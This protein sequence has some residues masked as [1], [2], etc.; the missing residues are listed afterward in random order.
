[1]IFCSLSWRLQN[2]LVLNSDIQGS[3]NECLLFFGQA[4]LVFVIVWFLDHLTVES[5]SSVNGDWIITFVSHLHDWVTKFKPWLMFFKLS[6]LASNNVIWVNFSTILFDE[7][8]HVVKTSTAGCVPVCY[9]VINIFTESQNFL[10]IGLVFFFICKLKGLGRACKILNFHRM[11]LITKLL[12]SMRKQHI[13]RMLSECFCLWR[14]AWKQQLI[15]PFLNGVIVIFCQV[16]GPIHGVRFEK[17]LRQLP[18]M[19][20]I[21]LLQRYFTISAALVALPYSSDLHTSLTRVQDFL[22]MVT[23]YNPTALKANGITEDIFIIISGPGEVIFD[24]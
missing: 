16:L 2:F 18:L 22:L 17:E 15:H 24:L 19:S 21:S 23:T 1:M 3:F 13:A 20:V 10:L 14:L 4:E 9:K 8:Q 6:I 12:S 7:T 5:V 11:W